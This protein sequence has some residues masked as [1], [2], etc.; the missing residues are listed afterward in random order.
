A[1][2]L[3][4]EI[5]YWDAELSLRGVHAEYM[6]RRLDPA[7]RREEYPIWLEPVI[8]ARA[9]LCGR[10][11]LR[12]V[13]LG[14]GPLTTLAWGH[15]HGALVV[16]AVDP[17]ADEYRK[18]IERHRVAYPVIP[19]RGFGE[20][21]ADVVGRGA[22]DLV[23][24]RNALDHAEDVQR[25]FEQAAEALT[26]G[27]V[28]ALEVFAYEGRREGYN[29]LHQ[30]DFHCEAGRLHCL[31]RGQRPALDL[32]RTGLEPVYVVPPRTLRVPNP[33]DPPEGI[34]ALFLKGG[35]AADAR[36]FR[37]LVR[38]HQLLA[39]W[40]TALGPGGSLRQYWTG[41]WEPELAWHLF[42]AWI[43]PLAVEHLA[44]RLSGPPRALD[45][46]SG[47][48]PSLLWAELAGKATVTVVDPIASS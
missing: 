43:E 1:D 28:F 42:P 36:R 9:E 23:Y 41:R 46:A 44:G 34:F 38:K 5:A 7:R 6:R 12:A 35:T 18:L 10:R 15:E 21:F 3:A 17:L 30:F 4:D 19:R 14:S 20:T 40:R 33:G 13:D 8:D 45:V 25:C 26:A 31:H 27:G 47:P 37:A 48:V 29:G 22:A 32:G 2:G 39:Y 16:D 11:P 24:S